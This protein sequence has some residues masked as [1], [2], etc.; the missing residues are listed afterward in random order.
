MMKERRRQKC[1]HLY[2]SIHVKH[3]ENAAQKGERSKM[4]LNLRRGK[5]EEVKYKM[6]NSSA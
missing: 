4:T 5:R 3:E 2:F 1:K 6:K